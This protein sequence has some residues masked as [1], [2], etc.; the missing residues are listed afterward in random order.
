MKI[1]TQEI[2]NKAVTGILEQGEQ[3][4]NY[5]NTSCM[6]RG[7]GGAKCAVGMLIADEWYSPDLEETMVNNL[8]IQ[9]ALAMS[10]GRPLSKTEI[11]MLYDLQVA[12]DESGET[13]EYF[14]EEFLNRTKDIAKEYNLVS[15]ADIK[16]EV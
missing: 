6:Y 8:T 7:E 14:I 4:V 12:H 3:S 2:F 9:T 11:S 5:A 1:T 15:V 16:G 13:E 10:I